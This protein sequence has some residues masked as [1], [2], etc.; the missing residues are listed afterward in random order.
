MIDIQQLISKKSS[1]T[2]M[3]AFWLDERKKDG[4]KIL[5]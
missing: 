2:M 4:K 3:G 5:F 1:N